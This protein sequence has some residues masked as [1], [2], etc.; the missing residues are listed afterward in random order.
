MSTRGLV[1]NGQSGRENPIACRPPLI[2][3]RPRRAPSCGVFGTGGGSAPVRIRPPVVA[4]AEYACDDADVLPSWHLAS[5]AYF[6]HRPT[7]GAVRRFMLTSSY[8][9]FDRPKG[10]R[11]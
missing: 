1:R 2:P 8:P 11:L 10:S 5:D 7:V 3:G 9:A 4:S 6:D